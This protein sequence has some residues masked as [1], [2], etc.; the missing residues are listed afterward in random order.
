[1]NTKE[2]KKRIDD[3]NQQAEIMLA[4]FHRLKGAAVALRELLKENEGEETVLPIR[5]GVVVE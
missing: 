5:D 1:M 3:Y 2:I 4:N